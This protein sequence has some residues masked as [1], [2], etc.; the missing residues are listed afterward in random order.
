VRDFG[1]VR[2]LP[3]GRWQ[4]TYTHEGVRHPAPKTF[5]SKDDGIDWLNGVRTDLSRGDWVDPK[6][7]TIRF[8]SYAE[9]WLAAK[10]VS[11]VTDPGPA[12]SYTISPGQSQKYRDF[13]HVCPIF[14]RH[15]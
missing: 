15:D 4:A 7:G 12:G 9:E 11:E 1:N 5:R 8:A 6:A 3:S 14:R 2:K 13:P 10:R